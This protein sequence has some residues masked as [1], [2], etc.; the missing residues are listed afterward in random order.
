VQRQIA[1]AHDPIASLQVTIEPAR[2][3]IALREMMMA[4]RTL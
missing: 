2:A 1:P 3:L 4:R